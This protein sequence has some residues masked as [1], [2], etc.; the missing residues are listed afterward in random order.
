MAIAGWFRLLRCS[1]YQRT[2]FDRVAR[3]TVWMAKEGRHR[4]IAGESHSI[5]LPCPLISLAGHLWAEVVEHPL[6][7]EQNVRYVMGQVHTINTGSVNLLLKGG[8]RHI[9]TLNVRR[10]KLCR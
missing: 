2:T 4:R 6:T 1:A 5:C 8:W 10:L 7:T 9:G 3:I